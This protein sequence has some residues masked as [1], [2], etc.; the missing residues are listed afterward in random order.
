MS[1]QLLTNCTEDSDATE[2]PEIEEE[3]LQRGQPLEEDSGEVSDVS[4]PRSPSILVP[5]N[6]A[7]AAGPRVAA[8]VGPHFFD[9]FKTVSVHTGSHGNLEE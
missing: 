9:S 8:A 6:M 7:A 3:E 5:N 2:V 1:S 4:L